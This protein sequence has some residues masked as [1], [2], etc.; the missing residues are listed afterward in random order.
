MAS[1]RH[2]VIKYDGNPDHSIIQ[3]TCDTSGAYL[4]KYADSIMDWLLKDPN[5]TV[6][7]STHETEVLTPEPESVKLD[8]RDD[9][10]SVY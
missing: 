6:S 1:G 9:E 7:I 3:T 5:H 10:R 8:E 2:Y 4:Y